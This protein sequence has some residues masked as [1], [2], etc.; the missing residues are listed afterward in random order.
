MGS[1][2]TSGTKTRL[3]LTSSNSIW[4]TR[5]LERARTEDEG[6]CHDK[7]VHDSEDQ[8]DGRPVKSPRKVI[9]SV[10]WRRQTSG[11]MRSS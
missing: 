10:E 8:Q 4:F 3:A 7:E 11:T 2:A 5:Q 1:L 9:R 6:A